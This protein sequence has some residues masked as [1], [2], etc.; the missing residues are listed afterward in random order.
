MIELTL[1][2][3]EYETP[4]KPTPPAIAIEHPE[5]YQTMLT[6]EQESRER[7]KRVHE[8]SKNISSKKQTQCQHPK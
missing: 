5:P 7:I 1:F 3:K 8:L 2:D 4:P 6:D